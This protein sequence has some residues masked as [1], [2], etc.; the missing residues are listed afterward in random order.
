MNR[1]DLL[2]ALGA[3]GGLAVI[4]DSDGN[5][6]APIIDDGDDG[7]DT[8]NT[9]STTTMTLDLSDLSEVSQE[10]GLISVEPGSVSY[11]SLGDSGTGYDLLGGMFRRQPDENTNERITGIRV[12]DPDR[13]THSVADSLNAVDAPLPFGISTVDRIGIVASSDNSI[14][15]SWYYTL[16][17][18]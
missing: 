4:A 11:V 15:W 10:S 7:D 8:D 17:Y 3:A 13:Q 5:V 18:R 12:R 14:E 6:F 2:A 9:E 1:R 16:L